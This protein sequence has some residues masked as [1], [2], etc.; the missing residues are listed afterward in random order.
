MLRSDLLVYLLFHLSPRRAQINSLALPARQSLR[1]LQP[2]LCF[3]HSAQA[4]LQIWGEMTFCILL[5]YKLTDNS[6]ASQLSQLKCAGLKAPSWPS[7]RYLSNGRLWQPHVK[8]TV[9]LSAE[10]LTAQC[11]GG[12]GSPVLCRMKGTGGPAYCGLFPTSC[13]DRNIYKPTIFGQKKL[14]YV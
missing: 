4:L 5:L 11:M 12:R 10:R 8:V 1:A 9:N 3:V 13:G 14:M 2:W 7:G 6:G